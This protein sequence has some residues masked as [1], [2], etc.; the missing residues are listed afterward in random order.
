V[1]T[2]VAVEDPGLAAEKATSKEWA[3][4]ARIFRHSGGAR[5]LP[6]ARRVVPPGPLLEWVISSNL[7]LQVCPR[8]E[9]GHYLGAAE[10]C[11]AAFLAKPA[12]GRTNC[13]RG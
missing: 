13:A 7:T 11:G 5:R 8:R 12:A 3:I 2:A 1:H 10:T 6:T 4:V 9:I